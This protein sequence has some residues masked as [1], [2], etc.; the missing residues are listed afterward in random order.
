[1]E[2]RRPFGF[3]GSFASVRGKEENH[4]AGGDL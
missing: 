3:R 1:M 2:P 4:D